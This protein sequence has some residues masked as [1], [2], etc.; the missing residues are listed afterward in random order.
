[1]AGDLIPPPSP[2]G[3]PSADA[4]A[5]VRPQPAEEPPPI[6]DRPEVAEAPFRTRFGFIWGVLTG[7]A[8]CVLAL[9]GVLVVT[10]DDDRGPPL[11]ANW[12][13]WKPST[14]RMLDG[15]EDIATHVSR[16]YQLDSGAQLTTIRSGP[17]EYA[18]LPAGV[19][20]RPRG[21]QVEVLEGDAVQYSIALLDDDES[22]ADRKLRDRLILREGL[23]LAL[24]S[25]RYLDDVTM[26][27]ILLP[28][29]QKDDDTKQ[30]RALFWRPGDLLPQLQV[31]LAKTLSPETPRPQKFVGDEAARVD[32][33]ALRHRFDTT[34]QAL[35][36]NLGY[37]VLSEPDIV[38]GS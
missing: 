25:F 15:A 20:V 1:V 29:A 18:G 28:A 33:L 3:R 35:D 6:V 38:D 4:M 12:S 34:I 2:A 7:V 9:S 31:P 14:S 21:G 36:N 17:P 5:G 23:E 22:K 30:L 8:V 13:S 26:V 27:T 24:Y 10:A 32:S 16:E 19:A 11:A 37:W